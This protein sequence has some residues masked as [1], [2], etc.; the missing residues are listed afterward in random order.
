MV[1]CKPGVPSRFI[2]P[3]EMED[4]L[5][6]YHISQSIAQMEDGDERKKNFDRVVN[7]EAVLKKHGI[8]RADFDSS[9]VYYYTRADRFEKIYRRVADRLSDEALALGASEGEVE[10]FVTAGISGDTANVWEGNR[11]AILVPYAPYNRMDFHQ[12]IDS[13]Y[14][15]GDEF[16]FN[17]VADYMYQTGTRD[18][19]ACLTV[20]LDNDSIIS[21]TNHVTVS[22]LS[23]LR[24]SGVGDH[25]I[26][27]I[28]GFIYLGKGNDQSATLK[29]MIVHNLQLIR[30]HRKEQNTPSAPAGSS[31]DSL[32]LKKD[33][34]MKL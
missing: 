20:K 28:Y 4:I 15:K 1:A 16:L 3:D 34:I 10:R 25:A 13:T 6:D 2:Q 21:R 12:K 11:A 22:G 18:A 29:L 32:S 8:T 23:Q 33:T 27:E 9:L 31:A 14:R 7:L 19:V 26:K 17:L 30:F 24:I 5:Y